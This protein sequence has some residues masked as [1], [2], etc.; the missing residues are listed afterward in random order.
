MPITNGIHSAETLPRPFS[1]EKWISYVLKPSSIVS[2]NFL[3]DQTR[4]MLK[5]KLSWTFQTTALV[6][7]IR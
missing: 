4:L 2:Y 5:A 3:G 7:K 6:G 1:S